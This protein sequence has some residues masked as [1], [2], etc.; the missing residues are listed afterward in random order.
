M[1]AARRPRPVHR[2]GR[3]AAASRTRGQAGDRRRT[4]R[5]DR[6][7]RGLDGVVRGARVRR[8]LGDAAAHRRAQGARRGDPA[9]RPRGLQRGIRRGHGDPARAAGRRRAGARLG[10]GVRRRRRPTTPRRTRGRCSGRCSSAPRLH[11]SVGIGDTLVRAK[12]ATG[13]GKPRGVFRL[14]A[15]NWLEVMGDA[16]HD[17]PVGRRHEDLAAPGR[18]SASRP[19]PSWP[20]RR[21][22]RRRWS[23]SSARGWVSGTRSSAAA[24][25]RAVVDDTP[26]VARGHSRET[27]FQ[28]DLD[29]ARADRAR[30]SRELLAQVLDGR[31]GRR[32]AGRRARRSRCGTRRSSRRPSRRRSPRRSTATSC[33]REMMELV[34]Q[35]E[36]DRP[37]RLLGV[38]RRDGACPT[39]PARGT[40]RR[41]AGGEQASARAA[42]RYARA[43]LDIFM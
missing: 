19:S 35:I 28:Q 22:R 14:T 30:R 42:A 18:R 17:R 40:R 39:T 24:T 26:W 21:R 43:P 36:P 32:P 38:A 41:A 27:T 8:R 4:R 25:A 1:G 20:P 34:G 15:E 9:G 16:A 12:V 2:G 37:I 33:W 29:R 5:P 23:P 7:G 6:A 31:R 13:F 10:R 3:G 11:C